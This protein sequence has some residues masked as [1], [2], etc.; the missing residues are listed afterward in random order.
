MENLPFPRLLALLDYWREWPPFHELMRGYV[1]YKPLSKEELDRRD[2]AAARAASQT[3]G[4]ALPHSQLPQWVKD[5]LAQQKQLAI[6]T[7]P[8]KTR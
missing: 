3:F 1:G 4:N 6:S 7:E 2:Q 8:K 5:G